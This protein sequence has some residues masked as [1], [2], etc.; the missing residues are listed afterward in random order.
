M[1]SDELH[2]VLDTQ[3][4]TVVVIGEAAARRFVHRFVFWLITVGLVQVGMGGYWIGKVVRN[5]EFMQQQLLRWNT[6]APA[7]AES[8]RVALQSLDRR[9]A[10][11]EL[12]L[13]ALRRYLRLPR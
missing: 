10:A 8:T 13:Q 7:P 4:R 12:D 1:T 3:G 11:M 2:A 5:Q 9:M 6:T